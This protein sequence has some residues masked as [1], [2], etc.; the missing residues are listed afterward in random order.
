[1]VLRFN[2]ACNVK[3]TVPERF[4]VVLAPPE[5]TAN[6]HYE[7]RLMALSLLSLFLYLKTI[8]TVLATL[9]NSGQR[10]APC[11]VLSRKI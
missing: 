7:K 4:S 8:A 1:M 11:P 6:E 3:A 5:V 2:Q 10:N 9:Y